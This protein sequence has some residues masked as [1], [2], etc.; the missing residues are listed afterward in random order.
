[1]QKDR[2]KT[3]KEEGLSAKKLRKTLS[4]LRVSCPPALPVKVRRGKISSEIYG[5]SSIGE[6]PTAHFLIRI[7]TGMDENTTLETLL[8]EWAHCLSWTASHQ[9]IKEHGPEWGIAYA[10]VYRCIVDEEL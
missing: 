9:R 10:R 1:M 5:D 4:V 3:K 2:T 6:K 7:A 8:H